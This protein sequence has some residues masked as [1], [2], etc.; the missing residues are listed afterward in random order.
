MD[1]N[2]APVPVIDGHIHFS[3]PQ[4]MGDLLQ[5]MERVPLAWINLVST[6]SPRAANQNP[7]L[8]YFKAHH[9]GRVYLSG[10]LDYIQAFAQRDRMAGVLADQVR[11]LKAIG[12][13]GL[14]LIEGKP[15][16]R[17]W[18]S[19]PLDA[20]EYEPMWATLEEL[21]MPLVWHVADPEEFWDADRCP[22]WAREHGWF[23]ADG[24][25]PAKEDLYAEVEHVLARH[26]HLKAIFAHFY[27]LSADLG[28]AGRFL[29]AHPSVCLDIT[30]G[31]EMYNHFTRHGQAT[32]DFFVRYQDRL[33]YGT[34]I[35]SWDIAQNDSIANPLSYSWFV[36]SFLETDRLFVPPPE[37]PHWLEPDLDGIRPIHLPR[38][39]LE[40]IYRANFQRLYGPAP[41]PLDRP[42]T[43]KELER[44]AAEIDA[45]GGDQAEHNPARQVARAIVGG[46]A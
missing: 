20:P 33:V 31:S 43:L 27:F 17:K 37:I 35:S 21:D 1:F 44:L 10:G 12:F 13:D 5:V 8:I 25:F 14:K 34:D 41:A 3:H 39:V 22:G 4:R 15:T 32:R 9:P 19:L 23:Y 38:P 40:K 36:R 30:P 29:D 7:A 2:F 24:T 46:F 18:V 28:R 6:P 26:P 16:A 45:Q 42:A 11:A